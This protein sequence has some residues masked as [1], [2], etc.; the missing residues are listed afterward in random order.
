MRNIYDSTYITCFWHVKTKII[1]IFASSHLFPHMVTIP[2]HKIHG[3]VHVYIIL[4]H[5]I[6]KFQGET[7]TIYLF[8]SPLEFMCYMHFF[9]FY[10]Y[11]CR[12]ENWHEI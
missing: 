6:D 2:Q 11:P 4:N 7:C 5:G 8:K 1:Y 12:Y 10:S 3:K 9:I